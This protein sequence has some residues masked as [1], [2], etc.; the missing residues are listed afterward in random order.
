MRRDRSLSVSCPHLLRASMTTAFTKWAPIVV[1][2]CRNKSGNDNTK[3]GS[4]VGRV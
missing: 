3:R 4:A 1:M 2:D